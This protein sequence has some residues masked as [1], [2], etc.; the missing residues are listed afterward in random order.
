VDKMA[1]RH[2]NELYLRLERVNDIGCAEIR[3]QELLVWYGAER[4]TDRIWGDLK[5]KWEDVNGT[6]NAPLLVGESEG[7]WVLVYGKGMKIDEKISEDARW[8]RPI[9]NRIKR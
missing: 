5:D 6:D 8:L 1:A 9:S 7:V 4:L 2:K 3:K